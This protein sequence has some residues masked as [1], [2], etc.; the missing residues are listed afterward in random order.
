MW[1]A[2]KN[3]FE[4]FVLQIKLYLQHRQKNKPDVIIVSRHPGFVQYVKEQHWWAKDA[5]VVDHVDHHG[6]VQGKT[7]FGNLP[8]ELAW[9]ANDMMTLD[10]SGIP[11]HLRGK[12][13]TYEQIKQYQQGWHRYVI[14]RY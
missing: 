7:V 10:L 2:I 3:G 14:K 11:K 12:E 13:L 8:L 5:E 6:I 4:Q 9:H 1:Q